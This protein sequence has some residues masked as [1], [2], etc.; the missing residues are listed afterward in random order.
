MPRPIRDAEKVTVN[1]SKKLMVEVD[2]YAENNDINRTSAIT[3]LLR[4]ALEYQKALKVVNDLPE[5]IK[6][7]EAIGK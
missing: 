6:K 2:G 7:A 1:L 4:S 5:L 3:L